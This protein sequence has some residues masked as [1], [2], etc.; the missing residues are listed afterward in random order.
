MKEIPEQL[1]SWLF[2]KID[3]A[4]YLKF[5]YIW[6][7]V[8]TNILWMELEACEDIPEF[9]WSGRWEAP[10]HVIRK[11]NNF[12]VFWFRSFFAWIRG[13]IMH[14]ILCWQVPNF[15]KVFECALSDDGGNQLH[16]VTVFGGIVKKEAYKK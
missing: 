14:D 4:E 9:F 3:F 6:H 8:R 13:A 15:D 1:H 2:L 11:H 16:E 7:R 12:V 10:I 5:A